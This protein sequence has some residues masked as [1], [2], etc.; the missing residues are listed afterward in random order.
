MYQKQHLVNHQIQGGANTGIID[1]PN[2]SHKQFYEVAQAV[3]SAGD[4]KSVL[5]STVES[6][7][8]HIG[9]RGCS[10]MLFTPNKQHLLHSAAYGLSEQYIKK[11]PVSVDE[12]ISDALEG[13]PVVVLDATK[14][15]RM[16]Y[17]NHA[18]KEGIASILSVPIM[19]DE[20]I[21]GVM[22]VY[23][24]E[25]RDFTSD[26]IDFATS[27][28]SLAATA[29]KNAKRYENLYEGYMVYRTLTF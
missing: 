6:V 20:D 2:Y 11:G 19:H 14:D 16:Q 17:P 29:L 18:K 28:A 7:A 22:R 5:Q 23:T 8:E 27:A 13:N 9:A 15:E 10:I 26:D 4:P 24:S 21:V 12:S 3:T 25:P 1:K